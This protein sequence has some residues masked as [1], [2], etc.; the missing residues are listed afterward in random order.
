M[1]ILFILGV[2]GAL[3]VCLPGAYYSGDAIDELVAERRYRA[4]NKEYNKHAPWG[5]INR[6]GM[7]M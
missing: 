7:Q 3:F 2:I 6:G 4:W 5:K 1:E